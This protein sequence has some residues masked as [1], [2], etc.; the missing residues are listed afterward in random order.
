MHGGLFVL[1]KDAQDLLTHSLYF[2]MT[3]KYRSR[4]LA[5]PLRSFEAHHVRNK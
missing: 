4:A 1:H 5:A 2:R 3:L